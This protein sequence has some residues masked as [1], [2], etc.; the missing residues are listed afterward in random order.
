MLL[1]PPRVS[2]ATSGPGDDEEDEDL[3]NVGTCVDSEDE[4]FSK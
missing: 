3:G 1:L 2:A 4:G